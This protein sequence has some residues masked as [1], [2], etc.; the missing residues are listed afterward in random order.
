M[1][2]SLWKKILTDVA[3]IVS[4]GV[5][6]TWFSQLSIIEKNNPHVLYISSPNQF[7][8]DFVEQHYKNL[9]LSLINKYSPKIK[10]ILFL[11]SEPKQE[12]TTDIK[13]L[14]NSLLNT[15][16]NSS[17]FIFNRNFTFDSFV[18]GPGNEFA[19]SAAL[20]VAKAPG[21]TKFNP[22]LIYS[23]VGLGKTHLLHSIGNFLISDFNQLKVIYISSEEFY[24]NFIDAIKNNRTK[25]F[26][27][28]LK[29]SD[30]LLIDD[31]Q[32]LSGKE[33][34]Q[35]EF[36][37]IFNTL[38]QNGRQIV[39]TSDVHPVEL[40]GLQDRLV[41]RFHWGL[42][43]DIQSPNLETRMAIIKKKSEESNLVL[44]EHIVSFIA[45]NVASNIRDL[46]GIIIR[47][48]AFSSITKQNISIDLVKSIVSEK[49]KNKIK[50]A[51]IED[52]I[53]IVTDYYK[54]PVNNIREKNRRKE[55]AFCRQLAMYMV[56]SFTNYS[57]KSIGLHF[58]GRDHST[59]IHAINTIEKLKEND[60]T[61]FSDIEAL[62][63]QI[64]NKI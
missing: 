41:S 48:L 40:K 3:S 50:K 56:K 45:E 25:P 4:S 38:Y 55:V 43:V 19:K 29:S 13:P 53:T 18:V 7:V 8:C 24:L 6:D 23:G 57:L 60:S 5:V 16:N 20:A 52:I 63:S 49:N 22:L 21:K 10:T 17:S 27:D 12:S 58:G 11:P 14:Q 33:S 44:S 59:V 37:F 51:S 54:V 42:C 64:L 15:H 35:E 47:L 28:S 34:T 39:L 62:S 26:S 30:V 9:L 61:V 36:F 1:Q 2:P 46:E 32:F 31:I